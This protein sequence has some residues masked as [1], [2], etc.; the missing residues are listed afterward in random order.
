MQRFAIYLAAA[1]VILGSSVILHADDTV[2][3]RG[4]QNSADIQVNADQYLAPASRTAQEAITAYGQFDPIKYTLGPNDVV[5]IE[6]LRH[7]EFSGKYAINQEGKLQYKFVGDMDV[8]GL[9]KKELEDKLK[10]AL[11]QYV[12]SPEVNVTIVEYGSK[13]FY[14]MGEVAAPGQF[15]M[16]SEGIS[17]RDAIHLAGLPTTNASMRR[18]RLI[19][20]SEN[21]QPKTKNINIYNLLY[22]GD[23]KQNITINPGDILYVPATVVAKVIRV[24][25]PITTTVGLTA[26]PVESAASG[27]TA[28]DS[29]KKNK[30]FYQ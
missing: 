18:C 9:T 26:S 11:A 28:F 1:L 21:G 10:T 5:E 6:I 17:V 27:K 22:E 12:V 25:S 23:L 19:T 8:Q 2:I 14:V 7:P 3:R 29:L 15:I 30:A 13:V 4:S 20:P 16:K 24:I